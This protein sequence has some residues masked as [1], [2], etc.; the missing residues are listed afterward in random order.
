MASENNRSGAGIG[1]YVHIP[2]CQARCGYCHFVTFTERAC[3]IPDYV[4]T[5]LQEMTLYPSAPA[6]S[7]FWGGG[8]PSL[9]PVEQV[10]RL[11]KGL[12]QR[13]EPSSDMEFTIEANPESTAP[14]KLEAWRK[15]GINRLSFGLQAADNDLLRSIGRLHSWE[16]FQTVYR[17]AREAGFNNINLDLIYGLPGQTLENWR[18]TLDRVLTLSPDHLS[19][20]ALTVDSHTPFRAQGVAVDEDLQADMYA[21]ALAPLEQHRYVHYEIS[22]FARPGY[23]CCHN[24]RYWRY[25]PYIGLGVSACGFLSGKRWQNW[26]NLDAYTRAVRQGQRPIEKVE[27]LDGELA[28]AERLILALRLREGV[29]AHPSDPFATT[30]SQARERGLLEQVGDR[31]R[32]STRG[33]L[34]ANQV[35]VHLLP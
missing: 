35:F 22:N 32:L 3:A 31:L 1:I 11:A 6:A 34:L 18:Q 30:L 29:S 24:L 15:A 33:L 8:T 19:L 23:A 9:L 25:E 21:M 28:D 7:I 2:F 16:D 27:R 14:D 13:F 5:L 4:D 26:R 10:E 20:Y 12:V 17:M